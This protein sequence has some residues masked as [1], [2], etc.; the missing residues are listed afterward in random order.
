MP[1]PSAMTADARP[2]RAP[3]AERALAAARPRPCRRRASAGSSTSSR[4]WTTSSA[5]G[6]GSPTSTPR[7]RS[8]RPASRASARAGPTTPATTGRSSC[9]ARSPRTSSGCTASATTPTTEILITVGASEA[10]G[11]RAARDLRPGRRGHPPRAVV[12][13]LRPGDRVR[14]RHAGPRPDPRSRTTSRSTRPTS[15]PRSRRAPRRCSWA[16]RATRPARSSTTRSRT[17]WR[18]SPERHDLLVVQRRDLRPPRLRHVPPPA[19][20]ARCPA[21]ATGRSCMGGF[22]KAYAMTGW[23]VGCAVRAGRDPRGD[24][25]GPPVRDHVGADGRPGRGARGARAA[26]SPRSQRMVAEYD[27]RRRLLVDGLNRLGLDDVRAARRV[28][29]LPADHA[30]P[31]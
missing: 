1:Y 15:R 2:T 21:C 27:R 3:L 31:A 30:R 25:Q 28:L 9:A 26:A 16:T 5:S 11:P 4:R 23:R 18:G 7:A 19:R 8:S 29:R 17:S 22:S 14:G 24:R 12:R 13:R 20:S 10:R 6:W